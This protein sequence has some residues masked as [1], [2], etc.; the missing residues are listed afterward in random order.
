MPMLVTRLADFAVMGC[1]YWPALSL[2]KIFRLI[3]VNTQHQ[4]LTPWSV[5]FVWCHWLADN[6]TRTSAFSPIPNKIT[7]SRIFFTIWKLMFHF[8]WLMFQIEKLTARA[9][10]INITGQR[11]RGKNGNGVRS[12]GSGMMQIRDD[13]W[14]GLNI[15]FIVSVMH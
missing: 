13:I 3:A 11:K 9:E 10:E 7:C 2:P 14:A 8:Q 15:Y 12:V 1:H 4:S 6:Q 5:G